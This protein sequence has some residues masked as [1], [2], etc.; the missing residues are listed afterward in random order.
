MKKKRKIKKKKTQDLPQLSAEEEVLLD[1]LLSNLND[2][3]LDNI[4]DYVHGP[5]LARALIERLP[6]DD[7][8]AVQVL[9]AIKGTFE[10]KD[11][12]KAVKKAIFRLKRNG[13]LIPDQTEEKGPLLTFGKPETEEPNAYLGPID[14]IGSRG[15]LIMLP[16]IPRGVDVGIGVTSSE[17]GITYFI[18]ERCGKK[19]SR[20]LKDLF[21]QYNGNVV[22]TSLSHA[23]TVME[24]AY[25]K[26]E[27]KT[28]ETAGDY[29]RL[30]PWILENVSLLSRPAIYDFIQP[31]DFSEDLLT[32]S[33]ME[34]LLGHD[35]LETWIIIPEKIEPVLEEILGV[36][37]S[38]III[39]EDQK[40]NRVNEIK[41]KALRDL[42]PDE[43]RMSLKGD[44]EEMAYL[45]FRL[46]DE[47]TSLLSIA[48]A[49]TLDEKDSIIRVN[50][51]LRAYLERSLDYYT[52]MQEM[53]EAEYGEDN[54]SSTI[55][56]L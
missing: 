55:I 11:I 46:G 40:R 27:L 21:F 31:E 2:I 56:L 9:L 4:I 49:S 51:F 23:A 30:R 35:L 6:A 39:S 36:E 50:P 13:V 34:R 47:K 18:Y 16:Q 19:R 20:E 28:G 41:E 53:D 42:F 29:L 14:G 24:K 43:E 54:S 17:E 38:P 7:E 26:N 8:A 45:F 3:N 37:G 1:S 33:A 32:E 48:A 22:E 52:N 5:E 15:V 10:G 12:Q 44:L 25:R